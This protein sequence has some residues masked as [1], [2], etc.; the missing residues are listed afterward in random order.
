MSTSST[1]SRRQALKLFSGIPLFPLVGTAGASTLLAAC[2]GG[3]DA[4]ITVT[5]L[6]FSGM[7]APTMADAAAMA[8]TSVKSSVVAT[9]SDG[10]TQTFA[11]GYKPFFMTGTQV[12]DGK[13]GTT[14]AGG[15]YNIVNAPI[16]DRSG[17]SPR[18]FFSDSPDGTSLLT[19]ANPTV[20]GIDGNTVFAVVQFEYTSVDQAGKS[21]YGILPSQIAVLTLDQNKTTGELKL[22]KYH[23]V[24]TSAAN[25]L[26]ITCGASLSPWNTHLSSEEYEPDASLVA[27]GFLAEFSQNLYGNPSTAR[28]YNYGHLPEVTVSPDGTGSIKKHYCLGR[29]SHELVQVMPD[30]RTVLMGD[31]ATNGALFL[32]I[33]DKARDL[34]A[35]TLY[36]AKWTLT[37]KTN[38]GAGTLR[39]IRLGHSTSDVVKALANSLKSTDIVDVRTSNPNDAS[40]TAIAF[41]GTTNWVKF[42]A[43]SETAAAFLETHRYAAFKGGS[44][45][46]TKMEGTTVNVRD[47]IAYSAMSGIRAAMQTAAGLDKKIEAGAVYSLKLT[48]SQ[49]D[50][51]NVAIDSQ[52]VPIDM[53]AMAELTG[54]DLASADA[55]GNKAVVDKIAQPDNLKFSEKLRTLFIGEDT[56][57]HVNNFL[58]AYN[59]DTKALTRLLSCPVAAESTGLQAADDVNGFAY[60]LSNF[61]HA[62]DGIPAALEGPLRPL[63][64]ANYNNGYS[65]AV[66]YLT[67]MPTSDKLR[68]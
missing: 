37:S 8:T 10:S 48:G 34:S 60:V 40:Y 42:V 47:K 31:D 54:E 61:Q 20:A 13:G 35:G 3:E 15:Y 53:G 19:L 67:G 12:P 22:V 68:S 62:G 14:L 51:D 4:G 59:V 5:S 9:L 32:F 26:W 21:Q 44:M 45:V 63:I 52:W 43:G 66:G 57:L 28:A 64:N 65:A 36:V 24:D 2:G 27:P 29:I 58:W 46:F 33:A 7:A 30:E 50:T 17:A 1:F 39:W 49:T 55:L 11:L 56:S 23:N 16:V 18:Q 6:R 41:N 25:G 38:G